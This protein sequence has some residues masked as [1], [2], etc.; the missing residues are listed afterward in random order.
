[1]VGITILKKNNSHNNMNNSNNNNKKYNNITKGDNLINLINKT[2]Y[3]TIN[4]DSLKKSVINSVITIYSEELNKEITF[5]QLNSNIIWV[6]FYL[7]HE[8][9]KPIL[10]NNKLKYNFIFKSDR[11]YKLK[12]EFKYTPNNLQGFFE[13]CSSLYSLD[14]TNFY[15]GPNTSNVYIFNQCEK[16]EEIKG[17]ANL[18][19]INV[20]DIQAMFGNCYQLKMVDFKNCNTSNVTDMNCLFYK[21]KT[22]KDI[23]GLDYLKTGKVTNM[24]AMFY[25][26][27]EIK[28]LYYGDFDTSNVVDMQAM[29]MRCKEL[30]EVNLVEKFNT[31]KVKNMSLMFCD[32]QNLGKLNLESFD[33]SK[34]TD[35]SF[36][37][38]NCIYLEYISGIENFKTAK[39]EI[40]NL[41]LNIAIF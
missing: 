22:L 10:F 6:S 36:M 33:T 24:R 26:C 4:N 2:G 21:C 32:C 13:E 27:E 17:L 8:L 29:F 15:S 38:Q 7:E 31:N 19:T 23:K 20:I 28:H 1:M 40:C 41:C 16:L 34:V 5:L 35:M 39:L 9:I 12:I 3:N 37:F 30:S 11:K 25:E 14:F 18:L